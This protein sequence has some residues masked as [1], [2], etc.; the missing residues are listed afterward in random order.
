MLRNEMVWTKS[1][2]K[3]QGREWEQRMEKG[4]AISVGHKAYAAKQM[5]V[6][7]EFL[8]A[9]ETEFRNTV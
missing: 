7:Q 6:W 8:Q 3:H 1:W 4:N 2:F 5:N 9:A